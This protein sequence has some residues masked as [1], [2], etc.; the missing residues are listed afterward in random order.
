MLT[1]G[2]ARSGELTL[3]LN[4]KSIHSS[5][6]PVA[7]ANTFLKQQNYIR[8]PYLFILIGPGLGY[9]KASITNTYPDANIFSIYLDKEIFNLSIKTG[10]NWFYGSK[11]NLSSMLS[12]FIP[13]FQLLETTILKWIPCTSKYPERTKN[14]DSIIHQFFLERKGSI[15]T[16]GGF[17]KTWLRNINL[18]ILKKRKLLSINN[19]DSPVIITASGPSLNDSIVL[20]KKYRNKFVLA[21]LSSSLTALN[22]AGILPDFIFHTDPGYWAKEHLK[23]IGN[24]TIPII[25]PLTSSF[26]SSLKNPIIL[27]NQCSYVEKIILNENYIKI[28]SHGTVAGTAYLFF[29]QLSNNPIIFAGLD[30]C[31]ND[32]QQH[33]IPHSFDVIFDLKQNRLNSFL[34]NLYNKQQDSVNFNKNIITNKAFTT[35]TGWFNNKSR[36]SNCFRYKASAVETKGMGNINIEILLNLLTSPINNYTL[37]EIKDLKTKTILFELLTKIIIELKN[38]K[39]SIISMDKDNILDFFTSDLLLTEIFQYIAYSDI[40]ELSRVF[41][42]DNIKSH[43]ILDTIFNKSFNYISNILERNNYE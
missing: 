11:T 8:N 14:I 29:R 39:F 22:N 6:D 27:I 38:F 9:L 13:D 1:T 21:A 23:S 40:I 18:N 2:K 5:Y 10:I 41:R 19:F 30:L 12:N 3:Y 26:H 33:V 35:Y 36:L 43:K 34:N 20:L 28:P 24:C 7:E 15:F 42:T 17:G 16:T 32:L 25:M 37:I 4:G 31:Y